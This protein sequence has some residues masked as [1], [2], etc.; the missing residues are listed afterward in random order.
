[1]SFEPSIKAT[2]RIEAPMLSPEEMAQEML[3]AYAEL[4]MRN[5]PGLTARELAKQW[6]LQRARTL[7]RLRE[8]KEAGL[9]VEG[10]RH[11]KDSTGRLQRKRVYRLKKENDS[12]GIGDEDVAEERGKEKGG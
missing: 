12:E 1:M 9:I 6:G 10:I 3:A 4:K 5:D 8:L 2:D 7:E 11:E